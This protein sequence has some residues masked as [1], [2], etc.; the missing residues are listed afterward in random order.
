MR[1]DTL[2]GVFAGAVTAYIVYGGQVSAGIAGFTISLVLSF[3]REVLWWVRMYNL[4][5]V[6]GM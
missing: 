5:E 6:N 3:S 2:G 1:M 4:L